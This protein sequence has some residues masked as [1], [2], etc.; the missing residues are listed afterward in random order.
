MAL[1]ARLRELE[2]E[3]HIAE[4]LRRYQQSLDYPSIAE[5]S[6]CWTEDALFVAQQESEAASVVSWSLVGIEA[7]RTMFRERRSDP[8]S[9]RRHL[10]GEPRL[11]IDGDRATA[12]SYWIVLLGT[13]DGAQLDSFG[14][15]DDVLVR[16]QDGQWRLAQRHAVRESP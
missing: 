16:C 9:V 7:L 5:W 11:E 1:Q 13:P 8:N 15:Y 2:D 10:V 6:D 3:R 14:R 4:T 12:R